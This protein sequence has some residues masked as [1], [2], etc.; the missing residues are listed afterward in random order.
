MG[1]RQRIEVLYVGRFDAKGKLGYKLRPLN[2]EGVPGE[3]WYFFLKKSP[4]LWSVGV[5]SVEIPED[6]KP[7][8]GRLLF[9]T[10]S[11]VRS[12]EKTE[13]AR[14]EAESKATVRV[15]EAR[16]LAKSDAQRAD[17]FRKLCLPLAKIY[18]RLSPFQRSAFA[19]LV[20]NEVTSM[21]RILRD[22]EID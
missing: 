8:E 1:D 2:K 13:A 16:K 6:A 11:W 19:V 7:D 3:P 20:L 10:I 18:R 12:W 14:W 22:E 15:A 5:Y 4:P 17:E 9:S 21:S